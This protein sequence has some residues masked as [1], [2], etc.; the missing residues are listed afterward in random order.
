M[1]QNLLSIV[2]LS[3]NLTNINSIIANNTT[4]VDSTANIG[5][6]NYWIG[7][8][9][10]IDNNMNSS[11]F[12]VT[13]PSITGENVL[14]TIT[15]TQSL[16]ING[17]TVIDNLR[18]VNASR[19][20]AFQIDT[21]SLLINGKLLSD[22]NR[23]ITAKNATFN[24]IEVN[25]LKVNKLL[26]SSGND[27]GYALESDLSGN[28]YGYALESDLVNTSNSLTNLKS[29]LSG[30]TYGYALNSS[31]IGALSP[32]S[33]SS[34]GTINGNNFKINGAVLIDSSG[35][36]NSGRIISTNYITTTSNITSVGGY[37]IG[38]STVIDSSRN[39]LNIVNIT[40]SGNVTSAGAITSNGNI[41]SSNGN[42][43]SSNGYRIGGSTVIDSSGN[44]PRSNLFSGINRFSSLNHISHIGEYVYNAGSGGNLT[45]NYNNALSKGVI[46]YDASAN[47]ILTVTN[48]QVTN[49]ISEMFP[50]KFIYGSKFYCTDISI[51]ASGGTNISNENLTLLGPG[52]ASSFEISNSAI[53]VIQE[54][55]IL[56]N[57]NN[58][59][60]ASSYTIFTN[61]YSLW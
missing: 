39:L 35:N 21:N 5:G 29:D 55:N 28:T 15:N 54:I 59:N 19:L 26:D 58:I 46:M 60:N 17:K 22:N 20:N 10:I 44:F 16:R 7:A 32:S 25:E 45:Y 14:S 43:T 36:L 49:G 53:K 41:T 12:S 4:I 31:L 2:D 34:S 33:I 23:N 11:F 27:Y 13:A 57:G 38:G 56:Y 40:T 37:K 1:S 24:S 3:G 42:I 18:N 50:L 61:L 47:F 6:L 30:N 52:G 8:T 51:T 48:L 9:K